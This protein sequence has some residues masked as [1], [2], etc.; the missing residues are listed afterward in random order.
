MSLVTPQGQAAQA[1]R[2]AL[3][4]NIKKELRQFVSHRE[5]TPVE[6]I[7]LYTH[8]LD[9]EVRAALWE[10]ISDKEFLLKEN[11]YVTLNK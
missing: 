6:I 2:D 10:L 3:I 1:K 4:I 9:F 5:M 8:R 11:R 7:D